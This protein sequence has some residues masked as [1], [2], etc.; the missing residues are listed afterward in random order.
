[1]P[2]L[3]A[4]DELYIEPIDH[5]VAKDRRFTFDVSFEQSGVI[6][7]KPALKMLQDMASL[8]DSIIISLAKF[9]PKRRPFAAVP[10]P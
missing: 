7:C 9:L 8:V 2:T 1:M 4:G 3:K 6:E 10:D 5:E